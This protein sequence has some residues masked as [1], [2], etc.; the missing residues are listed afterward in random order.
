MFPVP[1]LGPVALLA[2]SLVMAAPAGAAL[3]PSDSAFLQR[4]AATQRFTLG[5]PTA[6]RVTPR[7]ISSCSCARHDARSATSTC[8]T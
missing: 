8:T 5:R 6:I 2:L 4:Y 3:A 1:R 7:A